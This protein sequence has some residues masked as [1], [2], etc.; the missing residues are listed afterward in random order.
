MPERYGDWLQ[1]A[2]RDLEHARMDVREGYYEWAAFAAQQAAEKAC[3]A[4]HL[5]LGSAAWGHDVTQ[6]LVQ[7]PAGCSAP[8]DLIDRAKRLDKHYLPA[9][10]PNGF[11]SGTP[12]DHY[13][14]GEAQQAVADAEAILA[15]CRG[16]ISR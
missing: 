8:P 16:S 10:Y 5:F 7:L 12:M 6:L 4:L 3:K 9:R 15:F 2:A 11:S 13:T 1:R 14:S